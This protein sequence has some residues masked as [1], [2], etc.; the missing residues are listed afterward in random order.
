MDWDFKYKKPKKSRVIKGDI[1]RDELGITQ[2]VG[3][4]NT[5]YRARQNVEKANIGK[6]FVK[7]VRGG[8]TEYY[9]D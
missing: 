2:E 8:I 6:E 7:E 4:D 3:Y 1:F 9:F 5:D